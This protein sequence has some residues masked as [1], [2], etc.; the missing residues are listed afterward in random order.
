MD[1][2]TLPLLVLQTL[3][4]CLDPQSL[5]TISYTCHKLNIEA[6][7]RLCRSPYSRFPKPDDEPKLRQFLYILRPSHSALSFL[8]AYYVHDMESLCD[9]WSKSSLNL[10]YLKFLPSSFD[11]GNITTSRQCFD[12]MLP[13]TSVPEVKVHWP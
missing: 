11:T 9:L 10:H 7:R 2:S 5:V 13:G 12:S 8:R 1:L 3:I 6:N 4:E